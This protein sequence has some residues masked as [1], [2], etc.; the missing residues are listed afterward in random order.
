MSKPKDGKQENRLDPPMLLLPSERRLRNSGTQRREEEKG[1]TRAL[2]SVGCVRK[3]PQRKAWGTEKVST[4]FTC[5]ARQL[6]GIISIL[7]FSQIISEALT[8]RG[9][10]YA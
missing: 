2:L 9:S 5:L 3:V 7:L 10:P 6:P 4:T 1:T 8:L